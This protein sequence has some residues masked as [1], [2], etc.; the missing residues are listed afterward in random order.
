M[1]IRLTF[2]FLFTFAFSMAIQAQ[3]TAFT[4]DDAI[5]V[6]SMGSQPLSDDGVFLA[7]IFAVIVTTRS[8]AVPGLYSR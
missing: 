6:K 5:N 2:L 4:V 8:T 1:K 3:Q 7:G